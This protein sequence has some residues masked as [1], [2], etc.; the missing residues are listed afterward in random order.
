MNKKKSKLFQNDVVNAL[1]E[2]NMEYLSSMFFYIPD[3]QAIASKQIKLKPKRE[4]KFLRMLNEHFKPYI[5]IDKTQMIIVREAVYA[6]GLAALGFKIGHMRYLPD[7]EKADELKRYY[8]DTLKKLKTI[9]EDMDPSHVPCDCTDSSEDEDF[10]T[11]IDKK[12]REK[13]VYPIIYKEIL[14]L[15]QKFP[16]IDIEFNQEIYADSA[17]YIRL[18]NNIQ[19]FFNIIQQDDIYL[20]Q[21]YILSASESDRSLLNKCKDKISEIENILRNPQSFSLEEFQTSRNKYIEIRKE[22]EDLL[23]KVPCNSF[24]PGTIFYYYCPGKKILYHKDNG[25]EH[26]NPILYYAHAFTRQ[27]FRKEQIEDSDT[28]ITLIE[29]GQALSITKFVCKEKSIIVDKKDCYL[30]SLTEDEQIENNIFK[31]NEFTYRL[32][33]VD[34]LSDKDV[35]YNHLYIDE[36]KLDPKTLS[37]NF[38]YL[39]MET[40]LN[41]QECPHIY[42]FPIG[43]KLYGLK[44]TIDGEA[45]EYFK[46]IRGDD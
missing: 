15:K 25:N 17:Y 23:E 20:M 33:R 28:L 14:E 34:A 41:I 18:T 29:E 40:Q 4:Q 11:S 39:D 6:L 12:E 22:Y 1:T 21:L 24:E 38:C 7:R 10:I 36:T 26:I 43:Y 31:I 16:T 30:L 32:I 45:I 35:E 9:T 8:S 42:N 13:D 27:I 46:C 2:G 44:A 19:E 3:I 5:C 37:D